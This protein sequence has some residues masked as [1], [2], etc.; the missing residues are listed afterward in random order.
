MCPFVTPRHWKNPAL[1]NPSLYIAIRGRPHMISATNTVFVLKSQKKKKIWTYRNH[2]SKFQL[3]KRSNWFREKLGTP[4]Q[5]RSTKKK[6]CLIT[7]LLVITDTLQEKQVQF[8]ALP[9]W[10]SVLQL[11]LWQEQLLKRG[12]GAPPWKFYRYVYEP[13]IC[14]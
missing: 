3:S 13:F 1:V 8:G 2:M 10:A 9:S 5:Q 6:I 7:V 4:F 11:Q 12:K 14:F